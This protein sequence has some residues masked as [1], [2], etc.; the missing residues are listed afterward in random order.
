MPAA[1][2][3]SREC[4]GPDTQTRVLTRA[5]LPGFGTS[6]Q[7][8]PRTPSWPQSEPNTGRRTMSA[9]STSYLS[10]ISS[11]ETH[12]GRSA[13]SS[14]DGL[15]GHCSPCSCTRTR[16]SDPCLSDQV[17]LAY[18]RNLKYANGKLQGQCASLRRFRNP[19]RKLSTNTAPLGEHA[20][21]EIEI[22]SCTS[23]QWGIMFI[24][25]VN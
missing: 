15:P 10:L 11:L 3:R 1:L 20:G 21:I 24:D 5:P 18:W 6:L 19:K 25:T 2:Q 16:P 13:A 12:R 14:A 9:S 17:S 8:R 23:V 7:R 4:L 22:H